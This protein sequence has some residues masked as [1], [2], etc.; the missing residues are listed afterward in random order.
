M[1][2]FWQSESCKRYR[3]V[4]LNAAEKAALGS[5]LFIPGC[6]LFKGRG[7]RF[8]SGGLGV[9]LGLGTAWTQAAV[10]REHPNL[11]TLPESPYGEAMKAQ[12]KLAAWQNSAVQRVEKMRS[13]FTS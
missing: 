10:H 13:W 1:E 3:S 9:G 6:L 7:M 2:E 5:L 4:M 12:A 8:A 11:V